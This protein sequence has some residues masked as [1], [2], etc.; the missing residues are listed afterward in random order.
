MI[1]GSTEWLLARCGSVG[2]SSIADVLATVKS[3]ES[4]S[5]ANLRSRL[6]VERLTGQP[7]DS[8]VSGPMQDGID[9]EPLARASYEVATGTL[10]QE[11]GWIPHPSIEWAGCSPD[12]LVDGDGILEIKCP[13]P[14]AHLHVLL[15]KGPPAKYLPQIQWQMACTGRAWADLLSHN[16]DFPEH[17]QTIWFRV[18]R[19]DRKIAEMESEVRKF[20]AEINETLERLSSIYGGQNG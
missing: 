8:F 10:V 2:A 5:R 19:D 14:T 1:Q 12:G 13:Q 15:A 18:N 20:I 16:P 4:A 11:V 7:V 9:R 3:G 6:I 17:L